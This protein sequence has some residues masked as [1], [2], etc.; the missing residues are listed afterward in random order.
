M[1]EAYRTLN[2]KLLCNTLHY[3]N[4]WIPGGKTH[5]LDYVVKNPTRN[6]RRAGS[7]RINIQSGIWMD[8]ATGDKGGDLISLLAYI[9]GVSQSEAYRELSGIQPSYSPQR[10]Q[11]QKQKQVLLNNGKI[12]RRDA[13]LLELWH[14]NKNPKRAGDRFWQ[15]DQ[16]DNYPDFLSSGNIDVHHSRAYWH[17]SVYDS[18]L[19]PN[20]FSVKG[21]SVPHWYPVIP[22]DIDTETSAIGSL[23]SVLKILERAKITYIQVYFSGNRGFHVTFY[24]QSIDSING[25]TNTSEKV[26][27]LLKKLFSDQPGIDYQNYR[28]NT[29]LRCANSIH[30]KTGCYKILL[31]PDKISP[32]FTI[33]QYRNIARRCY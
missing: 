32:D 14:R 30:P 10:Q 8:F 23:I 20:S 26:V 13:R 9:R 11:L 16:N 1:S 27:E 18:F 17:Q 19:K 24:H 15:I 31:T 33:E 2:E 7:F 22:V 5:G 25:S 29:L 6:D 12:I 21:L 4:S 28:C 3:V